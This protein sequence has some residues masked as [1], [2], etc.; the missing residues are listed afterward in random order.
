MW[1]VLQS[2]SPRHSSSSQFLHPLSHTEFCHLS[3]LLLCSVFLLA[4]Y[5]KLALANTSACMQLTTAGCCPGKDAA[6]SL[7]WEL[8]SDEKLDKS[9]L[10]DCL[11]FRFILDVFTCVSVFL[12]VVSVIISKQSGMGALSPLLHAP[13]EVQA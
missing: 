6:P 10:E 2:G 12:D 13:A 5:Q 3:S 4:A 7:G 1:W 9:S 11:A 8:T